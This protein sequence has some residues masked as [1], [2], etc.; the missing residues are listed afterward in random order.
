MGLTHRRS[1]ALVGALVALVALALT[2]LPVAAQAAPQ[3][4]TYEV[5]ITNLTTGQAFSPPVLATHR[6]GT[7]IF[8]VGRH[9]SEGIR[10]IAENGNNAALLAALAE[11]PKV[12]DVTEG[13]APLVPAANPGGTPFSSQATYTIEATTRDRFLSLATMLI[14]TNDGFTGID[15]VRLPTGLN[16]KLTVYTAGYDA[17]TELNTE[18]FADIV[19]PCQGLIGVTG[20]EPG[21]GASNPALTEGGK[22]RHHPNILGVADLLPAVHGWA[23]PVAR[24]EIRRVR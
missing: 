19:P 13:A 17:G 16:E 5:T 21:T 24:V 20:D 1:V 8:R 18:Q 7:R 9:A 22:I 2:S 3:V 23:D 15:K 11:D 6:G 10:Q 4:A 14:C 12:F